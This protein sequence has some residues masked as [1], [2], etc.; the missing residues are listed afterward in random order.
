[1]ATGGRQW[2]VLSGRKI[3]NGVARL[4]DV[5]RR[6]RR[7]FVTEGHIGQGGHLGWCNYQDVIYRTLEYQY[8]ENEADVIPVGAYYEFGLGEGHTFKRAH[9]AI[10]EIARDLGYSGTTGL[11][12]KMIGFDSFEGLPEPGQWDR[13]VDWVRGAFSYARD[14]F[15]RSMETAKVPRDAYRLIPGFYDASLTPAL[16]DELEACRPSIVMMDCDFYSSTMTVLEWLRPLLVDGTMFIFD[17]IW[18]YMGHPD[19]GELRAIRE[20]NAGGDGLLVPHYFGGATR[21]VYVYTTGYQGEG[22]QK[23]LK[24][25]GRA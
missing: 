9:Q 16:R 13:R 3:R 6:A 18:A 5:A 1:M 19:F 24:S 8:W 14:T 7:Q 15:V 11:G 20:F 17:D 22:Y 2:R 4:G 10:D 21:Q 23:Y 25:R 12:V